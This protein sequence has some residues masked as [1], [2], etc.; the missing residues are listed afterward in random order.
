MFKR[1]L[2]AVDDSDMAAEVIEALGQLDLVPESLVVLTH[3]ISP[4]ESGLGQ[5]ADV[6]QP[7]GHWQN[8]ESRLE[9]YC[10]E[11]NELFENTVDVL[12]EIVAG[13]PATEIIRLAHIH[14]AELILLGSRGLTGVS[15]I[16]KGSVSGQVVEEAPCSVFVVKSSP[17]G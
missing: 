1:I 11:V 17:S 13:E 3:V 7:T 10:Q 16:L 14:Q 9:D 12:L 6:S 4:A 2:V 8:L 5:S 15:R